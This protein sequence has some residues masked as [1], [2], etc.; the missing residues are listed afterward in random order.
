MRL[1]ILIALLPA[2]G[3]TACER[4]PNVPEQVTVVVE[5]YKRLPAWA[6]DPL[7]VPVRADDTVESY[8]RSDNARGTVIDIA[9]CHR[10]LLAKLDLGEAVDKRECDR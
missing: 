1:L 9:N 8:V 2:L 3:F 10:H 6:T 4:R 7:P 5:R